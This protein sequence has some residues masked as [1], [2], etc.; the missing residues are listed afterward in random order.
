MKVLRERAKTH[1]YF[2]DVATR[3]QQIKDLCRASDNWHEMSY[4]QQ[5]ALDAIAT[6][7]ARILS[8]NVDEVD[9]WQDIAGY[10]TLVVEEING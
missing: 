3:A 8:G 10:A 2:G 9:H 6:K 5:E 4:A 7:L 1:G